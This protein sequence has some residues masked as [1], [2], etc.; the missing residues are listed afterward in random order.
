VKYILWALAA[1]AAA[2]WQSADT[3]PSFAAAHI[4]TASTAPSIN[5]RMAQVHGDR[6]PRVIGPFVNQRRLDGNGF[7][8]RAFSSSRA[9]T[10]QRA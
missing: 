3:P 6:A 8:H 2:F 9:S 1:C 10:M 7:G 5:A 4:Q